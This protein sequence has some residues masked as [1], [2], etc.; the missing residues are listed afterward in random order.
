MI[1]LEI[2]ADFKYLNVLGACIGAMIERETGRDKSDPTVY[3]IKL[4][5]HEIF[6]NIV[7][8]AYGNTRGRIKVDLSW[9]V[10]AAQFSIDFYDQGNSFSMPEVTLPN[11]E[12][13]PTRGYGLYLVHRLMDHVDYNPKAG[14]NHWYLMVKIT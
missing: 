3:R 7:E 4:A 12:D 10:Q 11:S 6:T 13:L 8:H 2:P 9:S 14:N 1:S 5:A